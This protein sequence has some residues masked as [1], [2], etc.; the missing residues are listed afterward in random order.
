VFGTSS[1]PFD[2]CR[3][4]ASPH[5]LEDIVSGSKTFDFELLAW[6]NGILFAQL[7]RQYDLTLG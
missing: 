5:P 7:G 3:R 2:E 1:E 6:A 4:I